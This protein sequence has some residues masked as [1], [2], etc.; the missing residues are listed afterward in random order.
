MSI[1]TTL[2]SLLSTRIKLPFPKRYLSRAGYFGTQ[3]TKL[4]AVCEGE[5]RAFCRRRRVRF[6]SNLTL[7]RLKQHLLS[8]HTSDSTQ[9]V[10]INI[11][12][13]REC[14]LSALV[15]RIE[16]VVIVVEHH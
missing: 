9:R 4:F 6:S 1:D 10:N 2:L 3:V 7:S 5:M 16:I 12:A 15:L 13:T 14:V 8:P 11:T